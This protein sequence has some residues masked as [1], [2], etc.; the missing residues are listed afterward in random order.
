MLR[1]V[2]IVDWTRLNVL[3]RIVLAVLFR[4][5]ALDVLKVKRKIYITLLLIGNYYVV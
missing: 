3:S 5:S 1:V 2:L 4:P